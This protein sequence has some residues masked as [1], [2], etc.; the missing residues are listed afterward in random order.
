VENGSAEYGVIPVENSLSG[1]I[2]E[3]FDLLQEF[4]LKI[5]GEI[6]IR[7][8]HALIANKNAEKKDIKK[9]MAPPPALSQ[10]K[11]YLEQSGMESVPVESTSGAVKKVKESM[12]ISCAAIASTV[13]AKVFDM[14]ILDESIEDN[15]RNFTKFAIVSRNDNGDQ[16]VNKTSI[17][18]STDN[19]PGALFEVMK[20]FSQYNVNLVKL[21]SRPIQTLRILGRY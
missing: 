1:S 20:S 9:V 15:P 3:N 17:I 7:I 21:E 11:H 19:Q 18:F 6:T 14:K 4:D 8:K 16:K 12:D 2:H 10:C 13:A 5:T